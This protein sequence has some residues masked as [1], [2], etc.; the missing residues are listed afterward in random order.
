M[1][2]DGNVKIKTIY[3]MVKET[4]R[5]FGTNGYAVKSIVSKDYEVNK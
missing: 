5:H 3:L 4:S 2:I 1:K